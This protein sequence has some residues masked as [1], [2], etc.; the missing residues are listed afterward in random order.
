M[1]FHVRKS[2]QAIQYAQTATVADHSIVSKSLLSLVVIAAP[3][4]TIRLDTIYFGL[5]FFGIYPIL[6]RLGWPWTSPPNIV[7]GTGQESLLT[8]TVAF[9]FEL[10]LQGA[11]HLLGHHG[12]GFWS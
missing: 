11:A 8:S 12:P 1:P 2:S 3:T 6:G 7:R 4:L 5:G 9:G 10:E